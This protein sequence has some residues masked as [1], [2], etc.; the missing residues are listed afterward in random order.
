MLPRQSVQQGSLKGDA[1]GLW[2]SALFVLN[3]DLPLLTPQLLLQTFLQ[4]LLQTY[5]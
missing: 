5:M 2:C 4:L 3:D 1:R